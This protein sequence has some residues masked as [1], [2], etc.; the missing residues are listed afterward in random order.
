M[1]D[2][3]R[4]LKNDILLVCILLAAA[5]AALLLPRL[6]RRSGADLVADVTVDG[7]EYARL[8]LSENAELE[9]DTDGGG[10]NVLVVENGEA[11]MKSANCANQVCVGTGRISAEG[12][13][14]VC[15]PHKVVVTIETEG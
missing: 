15:L 8:P 9:I 14:I 3:K 1:D 6:F 4:H 2:K 13:L 5:A 7:A 11:Y 10:T 12:E